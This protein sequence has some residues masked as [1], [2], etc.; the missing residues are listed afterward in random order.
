MNILLTQN[1]V[2]DVFQLFQLFW[3]QADS[4]HLHSISICIRYTRVP[5]MC[6]QYRGVENL[7][8]AILVLLLV[9]VQLR[10]TWIFPTA[11]SVLN[12]VP[13]EGC[14]LALVVERVSVA[15][16]MQRVGN[17]LDLGHVCFTPKPMNQLNH[18]LNTRAGKQTMSRKPSQCVWSSAICLWICPRWKCSTCP[19]MKTYLPASMLGDMV[20]GGPSKERLYGVLD[21]KE[22]PTWCFLYTTVKNVVRVLGGA[23]HF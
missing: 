9:R 12:R 20:L 7:G 14:R 6:L 5:Y 16:C 23:L 22:F 18:G 17:G 8:V 10:E 3:L 4:H 1:I 15:G 2:L 11:K 13:E 21:V 19:A